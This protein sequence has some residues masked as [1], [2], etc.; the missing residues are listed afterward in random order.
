MVTPLGEG[1]LRLVTSDGK[2]E[3]RL[4]GPTALPAARHLPYRIHC[5][6]SDDLHRVIRLDLHEGTA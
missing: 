2:R 3:E 6:K 1:P 4:D 5:G